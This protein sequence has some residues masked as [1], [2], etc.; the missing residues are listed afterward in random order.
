MKN[1]QQL[2]ITFGVI[3]LVI[4]GLSTLFLARDND[5]TQATTDSEST[6]TNVAPTPRLQII[7]YSVK[8]GDT[9]A[10]VAQQFNISE[11]TIRWE[12][13]VID[14][15]TE[16]QELK[17]LP[18]T[19]VSHIVAEGDTIE[20]IAKKYNTDPQNITNFPGNDI[21]DTN[22]PLTP[23]KIIIVQDGKK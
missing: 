20:S 1:S 16:G 15:L 4:I 18:V 22:I 17:I 3:T 19:G 23:G 2:I 8:S 13:N 7:N 14:V 10:S 11:D 21:F 5:T 6:Q 9:V 12:N